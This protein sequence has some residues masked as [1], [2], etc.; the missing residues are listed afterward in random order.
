[1][2]C[3]R[4]C[5]AAASVVPRLLCGECYN[6]AQSLAD[7]LFLFAIRCAALPG[8]ACSLSTLSRCAS[9]FGVGSGPINLHTHTRDI[10]Q[11]TLASER[12]IALAGCCERPAAF[13]LAKRARKPRGR[14]SRVY[15]LFSAGPDTHTH[16]TLLAP[17]NYGRPLRVP[18]CNSNRCRWRR[19]LGC[20]GPQ[21]GH[22]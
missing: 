21:L 9:V 5:R 12:H 7:G 3:C 17:S 20:T 6:V 4:R 1:M 13:R 22:G 16:N 15:H 14:L 18:R 19:F 2:F 11:F 8:R 10:A